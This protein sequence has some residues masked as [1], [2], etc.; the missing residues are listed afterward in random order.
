MGLLLGGLL[1]AIFYGVFGVM[2]KTLSKTGLSPQW[3]M[4]G[5]GVGI[6][7]VGLLSFAFLDQQNFHWKGLGLAGVVGGIWGFATLLIGIALNK[8]NT[9]ISTLVPLYNMNTL[10]AVLLGLVIYA[11]WASV[12][13]LKL[14]LGSLFI[15]IGGI[16]VAIA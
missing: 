3:T 15:L 4:I 16:L 11:E 7:F 14:L 6:V 9:P 2:Q 13:L 8:Y 1:P 12:N 5:V 10:V